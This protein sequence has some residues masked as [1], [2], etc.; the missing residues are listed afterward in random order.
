M[1]NRPIVVI[2]KVDYL[3]KYVKYFP[4]RSKGV[5]LWVMGNRK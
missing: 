2:F 3:L 4:N 5:E 1:Y